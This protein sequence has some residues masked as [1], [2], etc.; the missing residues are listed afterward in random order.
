MKRITIGLLMLTVSASSFAGDAENIATCIKKAKE[1]SGIVLD[2][3]EVN[4][5]GNWLTMSVAKWASAYCEVK[6]GEV[7]RLS[8]NGDWLIY[9]GFYGKGSY[10]LNKV[11]QEQ[12]DAAINKLNSRIT[13]LRHRMS[14]VTEELK[15][16]GSIHDEL[17]RYI[18]E[19]INKS[20]NCM[21]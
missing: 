16:P 8:I 19:G 18:D 2:E 13:L 20:T 11:L 10:D 14:K 4:Y 3:F 7:Y 1:L 9:D 21:R 6:M 17:S 5:E 12:T 15:K